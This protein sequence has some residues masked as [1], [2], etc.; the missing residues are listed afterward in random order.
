MV[1]SR[2]ILIYLA[3]LYS[4]DWVKIFDHLQN[5]ESIDEEDCAKVLELVNS[6]TITIFDEEYPT[7]LKS[8]Y[9]PPFVLFYHGDISL[10][11]DFDKMLGV[12]GSR[13]P[14]EYGSNITKE[15]VGSIAK[16]VVVVSGMARGIDSLAAVAA[17]NNGG[18]TVA[19]LGSGINYCYPLRNQKLYKNLCKNHLVLSE[20]PNSFAPTEETFPSRNR[21]IAGLS[22]CLLVTEARSNSGTQITVA[23]ALMFN[24]DIACVP[25]RAGDDSI[26]NRLISEGAYLVQNGN[27]VL[28]ILNN[29]YF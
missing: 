26:C 4:G 2:E 9:R 23:Q 17:I 18:K 21:I 19:I 11:R 24:R 5:R 10:I 12:I 22:K 3:M 28:Y 14:S 13:E 6:K 8:I 15:I 1:K 7:W 25:Y 29:K 20:Y 27:D 16:D